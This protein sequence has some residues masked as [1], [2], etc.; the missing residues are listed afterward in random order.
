[1]KQIPWIGTLAGLA[2]LPAL[3]QAQSN[4]TLYGLLDVAVTSQNLGNGSVTGLQGGSFP[5]RFGVRGTEDLGGGLSATFQLESELNVDNGS[6]TAQGG[7][8]NFQR[9]S[10]VGLNGSFG[11]L[12]LG[13]TYTPAF[14]AVREHDALSY[15]YYNSML[16][17]TIPGGATTRYSNGLFYVSPDLGGLTVRAS[18]AMGERAEAPKSIGNNLGVAAI[19]KRDQLVLDAYYQVDKVGVPGGAITAATAAKSHKM[20]GLGGSYH[21]G[22]AQFMLGYGQNKTDG[23]DNKTTGANVGVIVPVGQGEILGQL[24]RMKTDLSTGM[25]PAATAWGLTYRYFLSK[26]TTLYTTTGQTRNNAAGQFFLTGTAPYL[27]AAKGA[28][29]RGFGIGIQLNF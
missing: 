14:M 4:V 5:S 22:F 17:Y 6:G 16:V 26:R 29:P 2:L 3:A 7:G 24:I 27:P 28:D 13:R 18:Y 10:T 25:D 19:Y 21:L 1:M 20:M 23:L 11:D 12:K 8:L 9:I 15:G